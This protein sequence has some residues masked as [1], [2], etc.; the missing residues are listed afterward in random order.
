MA[1]NKPN[2]PSLQRELQT[3]YK[4][5]GLNEDGER[6]KARTRTLLFRNIT[7]K[8]R[9]GFSGSMS[10]E[11]KKLRNRMQDIQTILLDQEDT[12]GTYP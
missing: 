8:N 3:I 9:R 6:I 7:G 10:E 11:K 4:K 12:E 5:L 2:I 1:D